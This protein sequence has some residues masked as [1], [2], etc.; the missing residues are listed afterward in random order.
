MADVLL[1]VVI[2]NRI[3]HYAV[4]TRQLANVTFGFEEVGIALI[5][6]RQTKKI[7]ASLLKIVQGIYRPCNASHFIGTRPCE[8][9]QRRNSLR[10]VAI[11][12]GVCCGIG[13]TEICPIYKSTVRLDAHL[14]SCITSELKW[15][16][17]FRRRFL[18]RLKKVSPFEYVFQP[19]TGSFAEIFDGILEVPYV[20]EIQPQYPKQ[21]IDY[22]WYYRVQGLLIKK[23]HLEEAMA[24]LSTLG[25]AYSSLGDYY[26]SHA[27]IAGRIS[28][29]QMKVALEMADP[30]TVARCK[31]FFALSLMQQG[32][33]QKSRSIIRGQLKLARK[34]E[35]PDLRL[36]AMCRGLK[37]K[38]DFLINNAKTSTLPKSKNK[39][40]LGLPGNGT[41]VDMREV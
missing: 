35:V 36:I 15:S 4:Y 16:F 41:I 12:P 21:K 32:F 3:R 31:L 17:K 13:A 7:H 23:M 24:W 38:V 20:V 9:G 34:Q 25:G 29:K 22:A 30:G 18:K 26:E 1:Y 5:L 19:S 37:A 28:V 6:N 8:T 39:Q 2:E 40:I 11:V 14:A 10:Q 27:I 33:Y